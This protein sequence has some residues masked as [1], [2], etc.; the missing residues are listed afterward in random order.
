M[1]NI[2][3]NNNKKINEQ[4]KHNNFDSRITFYL[5]PN[6]TLDKENVNINNNN[7]NCNKK[8]VFEDIIYGVCYN[9]KYSQYF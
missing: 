4:N 8:N 7:I 5:K 3:N 1:K 6:T 2:E 9:I